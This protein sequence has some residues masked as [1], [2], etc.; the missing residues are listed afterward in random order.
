LASMAVNTYVN[1]SSELAAVT[2]RGVKKTSAVKETAVKEANFH[3]LRGAQMPSVLIEVDYLSNPI[4]ELKLRSSRFDS[5]VAKGIAQGILEFDERQRKKEEIISAR[6][7]PSG[8]GS[9]Q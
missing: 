4:A 6:S 1:E 5:I 8:S 7:N 3:V 2:C 9:P